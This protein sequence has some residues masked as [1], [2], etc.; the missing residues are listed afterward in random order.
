MS[1]RFPVDCETQPYVS[2]SPCL[3]S[4]GVGIGSPQVSPLQVYNHRTRSFLE[5][6]GPLAAPSHQACFPRHRWASCSLAFGSR[7]KCA[8]VGKL[9]VWNDFE[10]HGADPFPECWALESPANRHSVPGFGAGIWVD[11]A[12]LTRDRAEIPRGFCLFCSAIQTVAHR[13]VSV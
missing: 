1:A 6:E 10:S 9:A 5:L 3:L 7:R 12:A 8:R 11:P 13:C 4:R 2:E